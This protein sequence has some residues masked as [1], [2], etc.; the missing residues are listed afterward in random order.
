M[1]TLIFRNNKLDGHA[2]K[3]LARAVIDEGHA[4]ILEKKELMHSDWLML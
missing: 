1:R 2:A 3:A 4:T